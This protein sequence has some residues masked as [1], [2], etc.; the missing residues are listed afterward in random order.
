MIKT[1]FAA[2]I[3]GMLSLLTLAIFEDEIESALNKVEKVIR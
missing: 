3:G 2:W 1:V